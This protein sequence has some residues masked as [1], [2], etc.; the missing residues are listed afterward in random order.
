MTAHP[1]Q[2]ADIR[3][4]LGLTAVDGQAM[5]WFVTADGAHYGGAGAIAVSVATVIGWRISTWL[6]AFP[7][8]GWLQDRVY[9]WVVDNR[10]RLPGDR[11]FCKQFPAR[12]V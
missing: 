1:Y 5:A 9:A 6:Y 2:A 4:G 11:P 8:L 12:C 7:G 10:D 3:E